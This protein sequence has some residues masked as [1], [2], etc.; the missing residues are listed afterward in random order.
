MYKYERRVAFSHARLVHA[1]RKLAILAGSNLC[2]T[3]EEWGCQ[4]AVQNR[5]QIHH[6]LMSARA[7]ERACERTLAKNRFGR[8]R[9]SDMRYHARRVHVCVCVD[10]WVGV[11][12]C[13]GLWVYV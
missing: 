10:G 13:V 2:V 5:R 9:S 12:V 3:V 8:M 7:D 11:R 1:L 6:R 4:K